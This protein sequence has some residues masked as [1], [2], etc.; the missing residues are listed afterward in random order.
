MKY[1][2]Q[3]LNILC[4]FFHFLK[5]REGFGSFPYQP[6]YNIPLLVVELPLRVVDMFEQLFGSRIVEKVLFFMTV[7]KKCFASELRQCFGI[8]IFGIQRALARLE[9]QGI[10]VSIVEGNNR[11]YHWNPR[12]PFLEE[13]KAFIGKAYS[14]L[15]ADIKKKYYEREIRKRP[16]KKGK[17]L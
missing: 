15:P 13:F 5:P 17:P 2:S 1:K 7:N 16:R 3:K 12:Y 8:P 14:S 4:L 11:L 10:L 6:I 9:N